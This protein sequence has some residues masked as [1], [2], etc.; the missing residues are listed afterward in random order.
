LR[1]ATNI[2]LVNSRKNV[3]SSVFS[4]FLLAYF[5]GVYF[6]IVNHGIYYCFSFTPQKM[7]FAQNPKYAFVL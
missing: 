3:V 5:I 6:F 1:F 2:D 7:V 4:M